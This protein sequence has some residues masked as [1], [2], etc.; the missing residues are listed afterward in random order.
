MRWRRFT[1]PWSG[2]CPF[3]R[4]ASRESSCRQESTFSTLNLRFPLSGSFLT[5]L[6]RHPLLATAP[7]PASSSSSN[8]LATP[9]LTLHTLLH[10]LPHLPSSTHT[11]TTSRLA[12][13]FPTA[14]EEILKTHPHRGT[15]LVAWR[16]LRSWYGLFASTGE[17]LRQQWVWKGNKEDQ[18]APMPDYPEQY[19]E[20]YERRFGAFQGA[21]EAEDV[22]EGWEESLVGESRLVEGGLEVLVK[23]TGAD[24]WLLPVLE[25]CRAQE[26]RFDLRKTGPVPSEWL[27]EEQQSALEAGSGIG[28]LKPTE[29]SKAVV[30]VE[31]YLLFREGFLPSLAAASTSDAAAPTSS[32]PT[33]PSTT[34]PSLSPAPEPFIRTPTTTTLLRSLALHVQ[35]RLPVLITSPPSSGKQSA[36]THLWSILHAS[37]SASTSTAR[38]RRR[39][40]VVINLADRSL[41]SK[42]L[43]GSL[44]SAPTTSTSTAGTFTFIEGPLTRA[45]RQGRWVVLTSIDQASVEVLTVIKIVVERMARA[46]AASVGG[47]W[48]AGASEEAGGV[49][50]RV[51][52]GEG[53]WVRAGAGFML[54]ATRSV[55]SET[56]SEPTFF[57]SDFWSEVRMDR[58]GKE[59]VGLIVNGRFERL[60]K[61]GLA[62]PL[63]ETWEKVGEVKVKEGIA[64]G[65]VR[66]VGVR[67]LMRYVR[68]F[69]CSHARVADSLALLVRADGVVEL[70]V[71][72]LEMS[73]SSL[74]NQTRHYKRRSSPK[75]ATSSSAP[76]PFLLPLPPPSTLP[77]SLAT[78][79]PSSLASSPKDSISL[80]NEQNGF[81]VV[82]CP[83]SSNPSSTKRTASYPSGTTTPSRLVVSLSLTDPIVDPRSLLG[84]TLTRTRV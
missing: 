42:S 41:D 34:A 65:T 44:S 36:I 58:L 14:V 56:A 81:S 61:A 22:L 72:F 28:T 11:A 46:S 51:G 54:F 60:E 15:R 84:P 66:P 80:P 4:I 64:A 17:D 27:S 9:L 63:I 6:L 75:L 78:A 20:E 69:R 31:G 45:L 29:I 59:E 76:C 10:T 18:L 39:G 67:D 26:E 13:S 73:S 57:T 79:T 68:A 50:V 7:L 55:N 30:N 52:G 47:S 5:T 3:S 53:R 12:W 43:L 37:P 77:T 16:I 38:A 49:G 71:F 24:V 82:A 70:K 25:D 83:S 2:S 8:E 33:A 48:G 74:S 19:K 32:L 21:P 62:Q 1:E 23:R 40:L 35:R